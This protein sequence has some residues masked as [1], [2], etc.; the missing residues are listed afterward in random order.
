MLNA[1]MHLYIGSLGSVVMC[2]RTVPSQG[3][4]LNSASKQLEHISVFKWTV[5]QPTQQKPQHKH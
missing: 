1:E 4:H 2:G 3:C 5:Q